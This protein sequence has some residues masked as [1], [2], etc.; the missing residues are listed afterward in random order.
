[1]MGKIWWIRK[2][3]ILWSNGFSQC[4]RYSTFTNCFFCFHDKNA[5]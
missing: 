2:K 1:M 5:F 4:A 3:T